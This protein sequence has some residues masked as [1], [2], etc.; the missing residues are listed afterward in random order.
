MKING[1]LLLFTFLLVA[2]ATACKY[3]FG[4]DLAWSGFSPVIAI[5][6]FSGFMIKQRNSSFLF[7][8]LALFLSDVAIQV[9]YSQGLFPYAGFYSGQWLN[10]L[11]LLTATV[12]G[13]VVKGRSIGAVGIGAAVAPTVFFLISNFLV[14][15]GAEVVYSRD[16]SGLLT[17][18][19]AGLPFYKNAL[20]STFVFLPLVAV[21]Y[22]YI[23]QKQVKLQLA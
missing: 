6:L 15:Y 4:P 22:N 16:L 9:L 1:R 20:L 18:Y 3:F 14:W 7:P 11:V 8:L 2:L 5:A 17:C 13:W 12:V 10:Y 19:S 23:T 21:S